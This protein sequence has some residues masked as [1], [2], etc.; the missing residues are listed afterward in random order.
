V[1]T[2]AKGA[3]IPDGIQIRPFSAPSTATPPATSTAPGQS[4][5]YFDHFV[6]AQRILPARPGRTGRRP[7][8]P[9]I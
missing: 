3:A 1:V 8:A 7:M 2:D 6:W 4:S 9:A 5:W